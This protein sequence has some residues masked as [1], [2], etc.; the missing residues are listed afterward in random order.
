MMFTV[1]S[2]QRRPRAC[3]ASH[4]AEGAAIAMAAI[5]EIATSQ[6]CS[7]V[8][9][10]ISRVSM[11]ILDSGEKFPRFRRSRSREFFHR[12]DRFNGP[13]LQQRDPRAERQRFA[14]IVRHEDGSLAECF[15]Q[16]REVPLHS[17]A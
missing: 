17:E 4:T 6:R 5:T 14:D 2:A 8:R 7:S 11:A 10:T 16:F 9:L 15:P 1:P 13:I 3:L 12:G